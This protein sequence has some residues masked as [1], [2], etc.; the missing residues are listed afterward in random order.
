ME[1]EQ[2][3]RLEK[4]SALKER[5]SISDDEFNEKKRQIMNAPPPPV[6]PVAG[7]AP[8]FASAPP[9]AK[10]EG[11]LW[12][13]IVSL[14]LGVICA[15]AIFDPDDWDKDTVAG[16]F[17]VGGVGLALGIA[18]LVRKQRGAGMAIAGIVMC[19]I[20]LLVALGQ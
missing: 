15:L 11:G 17:L 4:L 12:M 6:P 14:V 19:S 5:G 13:A 8:V 18:S 20:G 16:A 3:E 2:L 7:A 1:L 9:A 10:A